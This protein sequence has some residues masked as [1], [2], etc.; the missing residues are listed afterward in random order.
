MKGACRDEPLLPAH[1]ARWKIEKGLV[2][3]APTAGAGWEGNLL[4]FKSS[5]TGTRDGFYLAAT[6]TVI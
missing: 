1:V 4:L 3:T 2:E 5:V 6:I